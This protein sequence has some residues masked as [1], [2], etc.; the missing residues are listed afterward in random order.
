MVETIKSNRKAAEKQRGLKNLDD[1]QIIR[2]FKY[3]DHKVRGLVGKRDDNRF[4]II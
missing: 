4:S 1:P 3:A 2:Q